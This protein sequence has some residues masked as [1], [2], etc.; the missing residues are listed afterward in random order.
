M[1]VNSIS[2]T[3][4]KQTKKGNFYEKKNTGKRIGTTVGL[5]GG[6]LLSQHPTAQIGAIATSAEMALKKLPLHPSII[7]GA[8]ILAVTLLCR[9]LGAIPDAIINKKRKAK[10]DKLATEQA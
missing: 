8:G 2:F 1:V 4:L 10:A 3:G 5:V 6:A 9:A 7:L